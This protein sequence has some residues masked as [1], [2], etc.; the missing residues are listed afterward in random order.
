MFVLRHAD[1]LFG[2]L[3][4]CKTISNQSGDLR[5]LSDLADSESDDDELI[6]LLFN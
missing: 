2:N 1:E 6:N 4:G 5:S 3:A